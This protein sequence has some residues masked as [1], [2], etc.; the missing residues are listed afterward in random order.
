[1]A[2]GS[3]SP[4]RRFWFWALLL[5][6][7]CPCFLVYC[8]GLLPVVAL[9]LEVVQFAEIMARDPVGIFFVFG[10]LIHMVVYAAF[11]YWL[12]GLLSRRV[13]VF[14]LLQGWRAPMLAAVVLLMVFT[15]PI[16][17]FGCMDGASERWCSWFE[18]HA[19]WLGEVDSC[20][21]FHQ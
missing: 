12:S 8:A 9:A 17:S 1:V 3:M 18:L 11:F 13:S 14:Q 2:I 20:G 15:A 21:D 16:Y 5:L 19:G 4:N 7:P 10:A 6:V